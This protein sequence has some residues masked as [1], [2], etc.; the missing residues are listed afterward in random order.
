MMHLKLLICALLITLFQ[1]TNA[2][3][4]P[5]FKK[6]TIIV[7][8][9][10]NYAD[11][12]KQPFLSS[13]GKSGALLNNFIAETH[14]SQGNYI[15]LTSGDLMGVKNDKNIDLSVSHIGDLLEA[16]GLNWKV[17]A[18]DYPGNCF[19]GASQGLYV[20]KHTP[21]MSYTNINQNPDRCN[22]HIVNATA[23]D[24]DLAA[25]NLPAY[26]FYVPNLNNDGHDTGVK[27]A[28]NWLATK[29]GPLLKNKAYMQDMLVIV[30]FD[31]SGISPVNHIAA[32]L[33]G[34]SVRAG[35][36]SSVRYNFYSI[37]KTI[38]SA[39][40]LGNLGRNDASANEIADVFN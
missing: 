32:F 21:F 17:Y 35:T 7:L 9:N 24:S 10:T 26:S 29:F 1:A 19:T 13:L 14:P 23:M 39:F 5:A 18:E 25:G 28:D 20:R 38:E 22:A 30:T 2:L 36:Q 4:T 8:E 27:Y 31:E 12:L 37:L 33:I 40:N 34:D 16:R 11:A 3:A 6:V 15:A